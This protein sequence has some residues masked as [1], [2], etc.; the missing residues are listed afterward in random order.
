[1]PESSLDQLHEAI[2]RRTAVVISLPVGSAFKHFK[3]RFV[4]QGDGVFLIE[5]IPAEAA[6][7]EKVLADAAHVGVAFRNG[8]NK[9]IFTSVLT[10]RAAG[11]PADAISVKF[12]RVVHMMPTQLSSRAL[13]GAH[14]Q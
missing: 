10:P 5:S 8:G 4:A 11:A 2:S 9:V 13:L 12:P 1:M 14:S 6:L 7:V 3:T